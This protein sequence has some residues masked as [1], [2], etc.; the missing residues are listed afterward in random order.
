MVCNNYRLNDKIQLN[1]EVT[2]LAWLEDEELWEVHLTHLVPSAGD[3]SAKDRQQRIKDQGVGSVYYRQ[4]IVKAKVVISGAGGLVEPKAFPNLIPGREQ[5]EGKIIHSARW[6]S[7]V[8]LDGKDVV[9]VG[10]GCSAAQLV[11]KI[12]E[13]PYNAKSVTQLM[14]SPPWVMPQQAIPVSKE[15]WDYWSPILLGRI[16]G[17]ARLLRT[18]LFLATEYDYH[19]IFGTTKQHAKNRKKMEEHSLTYMRKI[20]PEKYHKILTPNYAVGCKRRIVDAGWFASFHNSKIELTT[21]PMIQLQPKGIILGAPASNDVDVLGKGTTQEVEIPADVVILANG[22]DL[23]TWLHP[24]KVR[25]KGGVLMQD[26][27]DERG[28]PQSYMGSTMD[29]FPN[30]FMIFGPNT[31]TGH[32]SVILASENMV[33]YS[34]KFIKRILTGDIRT[35][36]VKKEVEIAWTQK[37]QEKLNG[38]VFNSGGCSNWYRTA[39]GWNSTAYP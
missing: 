9:V 2:E 16:P 26:V 15:N 1:T 23:T 4:E 14:R 10:T 35:V 37:I 20:V 24:L 22:F 36:E 28:G 27:W 25:G 17:L 18:L 8:D 30:F 31:A 21:R 3:L 11:P 12:V 13:A 6:D 38:T 33:E 19:S 5:F 39:N 29:G 32:S 34:L 7:T